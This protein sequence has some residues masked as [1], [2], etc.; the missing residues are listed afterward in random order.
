MSHVGALLRRSLVL[1]KPAC[2]P[3]KRVQT[4][5]LHLCSRLSARPDLRNRGYGAKKYT[6]EQGD[7]EEGTRVKANQDCVMHMN[8]AV[9]RPEPE[10]H[11]SEYPNWNFEAELYAFG[12]RLGEEWDEATL[13][14]ALQDSSHALKLRERQKDVGL[15]DLASAGPNDNSELATLG[16]EVIENYVKAYL[17]THFP[18]LPEEGCSGICGYLTSDLI[19]GHI[20]RNIG[21]ND[22]VLCDR[23]KPLDRHLA[24]CLHAVVGA[25]ALSTNVQRAQGFVLDIMIAQLAERDLFELIDAEVTSFDLL[26]QIFKS[27]L[28]AVL[29]PRIIRSTASETILSLF[30][31]GIYSD[32]DPDGVSSKTFVGSGSGETVDIAVDMAAKDSL[33]SFFGL[34]PGVRLAFGRE[35][36]KLSIPLDT[37][38]WSIASFS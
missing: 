2:R 16:L 3:T 22:L 32:K 11:R 34:H 4:S 37:K 29:E 21:L 15:A 27:H 18:N 6:Y 14:K 17:R 28:D 31:V 35:A 13:R 1:M 30:T 33:R 36:R 20:A 24:K 12:K 5:N 25:L 7:E 26:K 23:V 19:S 38:N 9:A 8:K 10:R